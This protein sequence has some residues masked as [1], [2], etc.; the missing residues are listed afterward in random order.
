MDRSTRTSFNAHT[1]L[2]PIDETEEFHDPFSD[3]SLFLAKRIKKEI[4]RE[5]DPGRW[6]KK[7]QTLLL[8]EILPEFT[9]KFPRYRLGN[10]ALQKTWDKVLHYLHL[11]QGEK[12]AISENGKLD[13]EFMIREN[14]KSFLQHPSTLD[15]YNFAHSLAIKI[16]ECIAV[17]DGERFQLDELTQMIW[18]SSKHLVGRVEDP[19]T[20]YLPLDKLIIRLQLEN[21]A[22]TPLISRDNL[23]VKIKK[24]IQGIKQL[25]RNTTCEL[26]SSLSAILAEKLSIPPQDQSIKSFILKEIQQHANLGE[27]HRIQLVHRILFMYRLTSSLSYEQAERGLKDALE[28]V[29]SLKTGSF[30]PT[31]AVLKQEVYT[32]IDSELSLSESSPKEILS[33]L[34]KLFS[35]VAH[36]PKLPQEL[37]EITIWKTMHE[38][39]NLTKKLPHYLRKLMHEELAN[40]HIDHPDENFQNIIHITLHYFKKVSEMPTDDLD[41]KIRLWTLQNDMVLSSLK[42]DEDL[43]LLQCMKTHN[44][45]DVLENYLKIAPNLHVWKEQL[46]IRISIMYKY[47]W[48]NSSQDQETPYMRF[49]KWHFNIL[50]QDSEKQFPEV[51]F[52]TLEHITQMLAPLSPFSYDYARALF[53]KRWQDRGQ[54]LVN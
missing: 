3:L 52:T 29:F 7:I 20:T 48:Y 21:I 19:T 50:T 49:L 15:P 22:K 25:Y 5:K 45:T 27:K 37:L 10:A 16:S 17:I 1:Y 11:I 53:E 54:S 6:S 44:I 13:I 34:M 42:F 23:M 12:R 14:L 31:G 28:Y 41:K 43:P 47:L 32:F 2:F 9:K 33:T 39:W 26:Q 8:K 35:E 46:Q 40:V 51:Y 30:S 38:E 4:L 36:L 18:S 24:Q